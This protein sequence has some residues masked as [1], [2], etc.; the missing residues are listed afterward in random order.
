[1]SGQ[2]QFEKVRFGGPSKYRITVKGTLTHR[3]INDLEG[4]GL[5]IS[6]RDTEAALTQLDGVL[7][8]QAALSGLL[9]TLYENHF[10][11]VSVEMLTEEDP[12]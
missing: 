12:G 6:D 3:N 10:T 2:R 4:F 9:H 7:L 11:I 1:M 5:T 8:D